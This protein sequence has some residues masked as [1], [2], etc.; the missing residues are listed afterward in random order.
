GIGNF[1]FGSKDGMDCE[2][3]PETGN[4]ICRKFKATKGSKLASGSQAEISIDQQS[5][6][7]H[8][9]GRYSVLEEDE[10]DFDRVAKKLEAGCRKGLKSG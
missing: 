10:E 1:L 2:Q 8:F 9:I 5:C 7:A 6:N 3:D 4:H